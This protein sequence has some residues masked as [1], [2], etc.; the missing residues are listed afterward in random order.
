MRAPKHLPQ[1]IKSS[2]IS[3]PFSPLIGHCPQFLQRMLLTLPTELVQLILRSCDPPAYLQTAFCCR[4]LYEITSNSRDLIF[5]HVCQT[6]GREVDNDS[7]STRELFKL[8][9]R[10]AHQELFGAEFDGDR[11]LFDFH[12]KVI[13]SR[14]STLEA[15]VT[16]NQALLAFKGQGTVYLF[17]VREGDLSLQRRLDSPA[18]HFGK[19]E[20]LHTA[21]D[22]HGVYVLHR[23]KPFID[24]D[25]DTGHPFVKHAL[26]S[27]PNGRIFLACHEPNTT[28][29][30]VRLYTFHDQKDYEPLALAVH[31]E[32]FAISWQHLNRSGDHQVVLYSASDAEE[33][34]TE[35]GAQNEDIETETIE[36][37][38][39]F[40]HAFS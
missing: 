34:E 18:R 12:G 21:V 3:Q 33:E 25:L 38:C 37:T 8:L 20:V 32:K 11:K 10:R 36:V 39:W 35:G 29:S 23:L 40:H 22:S 17:D 6:P 15:A 31:D 30:K 27:N 14:G 4:T 1:S 26:Q 5:H 19:V 9:L 16:R 13:D 2:L 7:L 28:A 24:K